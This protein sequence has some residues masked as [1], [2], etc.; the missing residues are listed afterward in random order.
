MRS[1]LYLKKQKPSE[2]P[3]HM[4]PNFCL[5]GPPGSHNFLLVMMADIRMDIIELQ[6]KVFGEA[7]RGAVDAPPH[8]KGEELVDWGSGQG[9]LMLNT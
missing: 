6:Q 1:Q 2:L 5:Q 3:S 8:S 9:D 4:I 7:R